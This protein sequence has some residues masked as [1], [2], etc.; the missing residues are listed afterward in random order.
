MR[1]IIV[2]KCQRRDRQQLGLV[3]HTTET[4]H[5]RECKRR[6][7]EKET[8]IL[9][10]YGRA[11]CPWTAWEKAVVSPVFFQVCEMCWVAKLRDGPEM[12]SFIDAFRI[13]PGC[14]PKTRWKKG[15]PI[16]CSDVFAVM[17]FFIHDGVAKS[18][19]WL[20]L[21]SLFTAPAALCV[22]Q[23]FKFGTSQV[24]LHFATLC[25]TSPVTQPLEMPWRLYSLICHEYL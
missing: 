23:R 6:T 12:Q 1:Y 4:V 16:C 13:S 9:G 2:L 22:P 20:Q 18:L 3:L 17:W 5:C 24:F 25:V 14:L 7:R 11:C 21:L 10:C 19:M 15:R 8:P